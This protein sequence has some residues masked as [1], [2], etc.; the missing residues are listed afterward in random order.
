MGSA[1]IG[2][3]DGCKFRIPPSY[4]N[5]SMWDNSTFDGFLGLIMD[6]FDWP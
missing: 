3:S 5:V 1:T 4:F 6:E 2:D